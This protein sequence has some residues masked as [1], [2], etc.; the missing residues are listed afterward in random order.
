[1]EGGK[2]AEGTDKQDIEFIKSYLKSSL[3][4]ETQKRIAEDTFHELTK[5]EKIWQEKMSYTAKKQNAGL[6]LIEMLFMAG[7]GF[8]LSVLVLFVVMIMAEMFDLSVFLELFLLLA[9]VIIP[10][11]LIIVRPI[12]KKIED[13]RSI[14]EKFI[15]DQQ[16]EASIKQQ[17]KEALYIIQNNKAKLKRAYQYTVN[18]LRDTYSAN[19]IYKKY[20]TVE[21]CA[22]IYDYLQSGRCYCLEGPYGAYNKYEDDLANGIII[23]H[24]TEINN[25]MDI[26]I[27]NQEKTYSIAREIQQ[28]VN[29]M[30]ED[31]R[32]VCESLKGIDDKLDNIANHTKITAWTSSILATQVP[33]WEAE[34]KHQLNK[35]YV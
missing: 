14:K 31:M 3:E 15:L 10:I 12:Y 6:T 7:K 4:L 22:A 24:L 26:I 16:R 5:E 33:D 13:C 9:S 20:Q 29:G 18:G 8:F 25:K 21:A 27:A 32:L 28:S 23:K 19:I 2:M 30:K 17:G 11:V 1:M 34:A 35:I